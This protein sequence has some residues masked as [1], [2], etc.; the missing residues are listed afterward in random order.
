MRAFWQL[1]SMRAIGFAAA[2]PLPYES[3]VRH[4]EARGMEP[5]EVD[6]AVEILRE[7][8][9]GYMKHQAAQARKEAGGRRSEE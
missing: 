6:M 3:I 9:A 1:D 7:M 2:G 4:F 5:Y 8:D